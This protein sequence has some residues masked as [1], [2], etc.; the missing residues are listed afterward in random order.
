V[1]GWLGK[2]SKVVVIVDVADLKT[3]ELQQEIVKLRRRVKKLTALLRLALALLRT[4]GFT[5]THERL[6]EGR[7]KI[8]ILRGVDGARDV[9]PLGALVRFLQL[10][11]SRFHTWRR[12]Q[13]VCSLDDRS[14]CP[15]TS[16]HRQTQLEVQVIKDMVT[17]PECRHVPTAR[18]PS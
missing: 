17:G 1:G 16:P 5:L 10:S 7:A 6:P 8:R 4:S 15:H 12:L 18:L 9:V 14:S 11:P 3:P 13:P 2:A